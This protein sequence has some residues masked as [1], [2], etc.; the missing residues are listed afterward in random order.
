[1]SGTPIRIATRASGLAL[2]QADHVA[3]LMRR[4]APHLSVELVHV[5]TA[6]DRDRTAA[7][8]AIGTLGLFTREVQSALLD[9]R[10]DVAVHSLKDLPTE[11]VDGLVLAGVPER[12]SPHDVLVLPRKGDSTSPSTVEGR[13]ALSMLA[14]EARVGTGSLRRRAQLLHLR[15]DLEMRDVRGNVETRIQKLD[16]GEFDAL[17]LAEAGLRRLELASRIACVLCPPLMYGAVG[18]GALGLECRGDDDELR[19]LLESIS[20]PP[21]RL[22]VTAERALLARLKAGCHAP[23]GVST[24]LGAERLTLTAVAL[25]PDGSERIAAESSG[26]AGDPHRVAEDVA[27]A[28]VAQGAARWI[29][30]PDRET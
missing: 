27:N 1:M 16:G 23:L 26:P 17:V 24:N 3:G 30:S 6:G 11:P 7:L 8:A 22:A 10:A 20:H 2:W 14:P 29:T 9:R 5:T 25:S 21:S 4:A 12:A 15:S 19:T 18:Q 13:E 28:L